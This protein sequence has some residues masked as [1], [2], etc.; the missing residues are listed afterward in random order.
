LKRSFLP[1]LIVGALAATF[2]FVGKGC[3]QVLLNVTYGSQGIEQLSYNGIG[4]EDVGQYPSDVFHIWH[5]KTTDLKGNILSQGQ[6]GWGENNN[7]RTWNAQTHTWTYTFIWGSISVAFEQVSDTLKMV[8][9]TT[10]NTNSGVIFDGAS[11]YPFVLHFPQLPAGFGVAGTPQLSYNTTAPSVMLADYS[12]GEVAA[13]VPDATRPLY[14]GFWPA[15]PAN[16]YTAMVSTTT[17]DGLAV[18]LPRNDR[19]IMPGQSDTASVSL[20]FAPSGTSLSQLA[21]DIYKNWAAAWPEKLFWGDRRIVGTVY[22]ASSPQGDPSKPGGY[23]NNPRRYFNDSNAK[24]FNIN[25]AA[26]LAA[27]QGRVLRQA[28]G[29]VQN[30]Q[31]LNAQGAITWDIEGEQYPQPTSYACSPDQIALL[32]P[33]MESIVNGQASPYNGMKL[34]DAYFKTMR[35]AGFK[36]GVCVRPQ[37][38]VLASSGRAQQVYLSDANVE[39]ELLGKMKVAHD[40][41]GATIFYV[42]SSVEPDGA[43]L[44][45]DIYKLLQAAMPY[46]LIVPEESTPKHYAYTAPFL[47]F[48]DHGDLG[49]NSGIYSYYPHGFSLNLINDV[50]PQLLAQYTPQLT[51]SVRRGD[52]LMVHAD[53]WQANNPVVMQIYQ[54]ASSSK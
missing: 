6:Y 41:W 47:S 48:I 3:A 52:I 18:F 34:D 23:P 7:G 17:P 9:T 44:S 25:T 4:L 42:D 49:T 5:M 40:R 36:V 16:S 54:A 22:L 27:F 51:E 37:H 29:N 21:A 13:V 28:A 39:A 33:E 43:V 45:P 10:N 12:Q 11:I 53:Y 1:I 2:S 38:F 50:N 24:D 31:R 26:G 35:D 15:S 8:V 30:M 19:P 20:R 32:A 46:A 14:S